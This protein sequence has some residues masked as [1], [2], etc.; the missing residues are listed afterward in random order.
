MRLEMA[1]MLIVPESGSVSILFLPLNLLR[2]HLALPCQ[3]HGPRTRTTNHHSDNWSLVF[4]LLGMVDSAVQVGGQHA[5]AAWLA[6]VNAYAFEC[7]ED[8]VD[9]GQHLRIRQVQYPS[10]LALVV[11]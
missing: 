8:R 11:V 3:P 9:L 7:N 5:L 1:T 6:T 10:F 4:C 2:F